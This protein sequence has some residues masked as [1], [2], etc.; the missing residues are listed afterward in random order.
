MLE[1]GLRF[2]EDCVKE[3]GF[4]TYFSDA[5]KRNFGAKGRSKQ[6]PYKSF[7]ATKKYK[8]LEPHV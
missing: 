4:Q 1:I 5:R 3:K 6:R 8:N 7:R 2:V